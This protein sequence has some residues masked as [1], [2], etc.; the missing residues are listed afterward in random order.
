MA[1]PHRYDV[2][3]VVLTQVEKKGLSYLRSSKMYTVNSEEPY[4]NKIVDKTQKYKIY[5]GEC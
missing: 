1:N 2:N 4:G 3:R 5:A